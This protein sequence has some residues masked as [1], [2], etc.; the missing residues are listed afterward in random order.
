[1]SDQKSWMEKVQENAVLFSEAIEALLAPR[2]GSLVFINEQNLGDDFTSNGLYFDPDS[3][4]GLLAKIIKIENNVSVQP[5]SAEPDNRIYIV[6]GE[7]KIIVR[8]LRYDNGKEM[9]INLGGE[10][11]DDSFDLIPLV[12]SLEDSELWDGD[13]NSIVFLSDDQ[14]LLV[15]QFAENARLGLEKFSQDVC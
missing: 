8:V 7:L 4:N 6:S 10:D 1:M 5:E 9:E 15:R 14:L 12:K 11:Y 13:G 3:N 2:V